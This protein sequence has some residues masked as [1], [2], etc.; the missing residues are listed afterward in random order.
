MHRFI[1]IYLEGE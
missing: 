1:G